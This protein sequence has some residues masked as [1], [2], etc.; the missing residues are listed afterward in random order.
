MRN[1]R[2]ALL[3]VALLACFCATAR[4]AGE[5][6]LQVLFVGNSLT[7]V[8]NLP[9]VLEALATG[10]R[11]PLQADMIVKGGA[12][13]TQWLDSRAVP[14]ALEAKHYDYVVL[15]ERGNDFACGF[16]PQV[17]KD[18][19]H[20]LHALAGIVRSAGAQPILL[21]TYEPDVDGAANLVDAEVKAARGN[22]MPYI[23]V[24]NRFVTGM[25]RYPNADWVRADH[26][27]G[28]AL[29]LL[30]AVLLYRQLY[31]TLP[32]PI[33]FDAK[34]PMYVPGSQFA[35]P[36]PLSVSLGNKAVASGHRYTRADLKR[37]IS[38]AR[39]D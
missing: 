35:A 11:N 36:D 12:T 25:R 14:R 33:P 18:S 31:G 21:G 23:A 6:P 29:V 17:C 13:L 2:C 24:S 19:R 16:G 20:A 5:K 3:L 32:L 22:G 8:G 34:A 15:Q 9:A 7:Y 4:A 30:E 39:G 37:T 10:S 27:P 26:H 38:L 28:S 1:T